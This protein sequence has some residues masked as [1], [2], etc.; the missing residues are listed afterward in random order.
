MGGLEDRAE[1]LYYRAATALR[2]RTSAY[3]TDQPAQLQ[4]QLRYRELVDAGSPLPQLAEVGWRRYSQFDEDGQL[5][6]LLSV[7][8]SGTKRIVDI[9]CGR[10]M[11]SNATNLLVNW[12]WQGLGLD[13]DAANIAAATRWYRRNRATMF[14]P[15]QLRTA[16]VSP[17]NVGALI[18]DAGFGDGIDVLS[19]D[20]DGLDLWIWQ[21]IEATPRIVA[22]EFNAQLPSDRSITV[23]MRDPITTPEANRAGHIGASLAALVRLGASKGYRFVGVSAGVNAWFVHSSAP[24]AELL[25]EADVTE[26]LDRPVSAYRRPPRAD[27][28]VLAMEWVEV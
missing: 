24:N 14:A 20:V 15:P 13:G 16:V 5:L 7:V 6:F 27:D 4:L 2:E 11:G 3:W 12:G 21:A 8:G 22:I 10:P 17:D 18:A 9:G 25:P 1:N 28:P 26:A 23:P 19:I